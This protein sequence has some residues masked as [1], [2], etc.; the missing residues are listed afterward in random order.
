M[1]EIILWQGNKNIQRHYNLDTN[2]YAPGAIS[3]KTKEI[4]RMVASMVLFLMMVSV[5]TSK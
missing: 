5:I 1:N 3:L 4:M 2:I